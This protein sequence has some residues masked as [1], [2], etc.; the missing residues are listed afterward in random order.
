MK[1]IP[2]A[3][4]KADLAKYLQLAEEEE[5]VI[6]RDGSPVGV[7]IGFA[8]EDDWFEYRLEHDPRFLQRIAEA[9]ASLRAGTGVRLE[10]VEE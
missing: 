8:T 4:V 7:L 3:D 9:R 6:T 5:I 1:H 10:D 2:L